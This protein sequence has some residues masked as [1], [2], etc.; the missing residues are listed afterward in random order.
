MVATRTGTSVELTWFD[1]ADNEARY[2]IRDV[3]T[4]SELEELPADSDSFVVEPVL[5]EPACFDVVAEN[6]A[7]SGVSEVPGCD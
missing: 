5:S 7:G 2:S 1:T 4:A 6:E 3:T